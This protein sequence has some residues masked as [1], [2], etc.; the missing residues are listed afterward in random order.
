MK[1]IERLLSMAFF[2][3]RV[4]DGRQNPRVNPGCSLL[5]AIVSPGII[6]SRKRIKKSPSPEEEGLGYSSKCL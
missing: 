6:T 2:I 1:A 3:G 5:P 4:V